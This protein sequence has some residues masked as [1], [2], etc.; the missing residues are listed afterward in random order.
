[1]LAERLYVFEVTVA[2]NRRGEPSLDGSALERFGEVRALALDEALELCRNGT[3]MDGK[4]EL[5]L[6]RLAERHGSRRA[7]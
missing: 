5:A 1:M 3:L 2:P 7:P 6:R 4:T